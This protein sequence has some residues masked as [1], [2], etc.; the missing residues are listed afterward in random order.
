MLAEPLA[1][2]LTAQVQ[3]TD[4]INGERK[5]VYK[6]YLEGLAP[7]VDER[8]ISF[9]EIPAGC[10]PNWH[11]F[12]L[13]VLDEEDRNALLAHLKGKGVTAT[14]HYLPLHTSPFARA[15]LKTNEGDLPVTE[16]VAATLVRLPLFPTMKEEEIERV[17]DG[18]Y[19]FFGK[20]RPVSG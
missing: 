4:L 15:N 9:Q 8:L 14:F 3:R 18:V 16:R 6:R 7:L 17:I 20:G 19:G 13:R 1:A 11:I 12:S 2:L 5:R 10:E